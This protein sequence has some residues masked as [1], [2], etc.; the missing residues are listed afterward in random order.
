MVLFF[1]GLFI[2]PFPLTSSLP[3]QQNA[4]FID[5]TA[6]V[7]PVLADG[8]LNR[9]IRV[10]VYDEPNTTLPDYATGG[11][12]TNTISG[13][14]GIL[15][16]AGYQVDTIT[17]TDIQERRLS[18]AN[19][20]VF[21]MVSNIPREKITNHVREFWLGGGGIMGFGVS[22][23]YMSYFGLLGPYY[24][25]DFG[26]EYV[27]SK[28]I[29]ANLVMNNFNVT[30]RHPTATQFHINDEIIHPPDTITVFNNQGLETN[31]DNQVTTVVTEVPNMG[32]VLAIDND[33]KGGRQVI[34]CGNGTDYPAGFDSIIVDSANWIAPR[35][36]GRIVFDLSHRPR[37]GV[38]PWD[39]VSY[40]GY[41]PGFRDL[42]VN[43]TF[44]FDK[45][46][47]SFAGNLTIDRLSSYDILI[48][49]SPDYNYTSSEVAAVQS[50]L[51]Q[52]GS[53]F[54]FGEN[55]NLST[56]GKSNE[57]INSITQN[58]GIYIN[59]TLGT[60]SP[61][62]VDPMLYFT[63]EGCTILYMTSRGFVNVTGDAVGLW[64][65]WPDFNIGSSFL[66]AG[67][68]VVSA[69]MN[70]I[71]DSQLMLDDN[72][73]FAVN[74]AN[75]LSSTKADVVVYQSGTVPTGQNVYR[76][77]LSNALNELG[78]PF[79][80]YTNITYFNLSLVY[81]TWDTVIVDANSISPVSFY[82]EILE[83]MENGGKLIMRDFYFYHSASSSSY[84]LSLDH[85]LGFV[86][87]DSRIISG[88]VP[89]FPWTPEHPVFNV[90]NDYGASNITPDS[91]FLAT[92][93]ANVTLLS[94]ATA[95]A[96]ITESPAINQSAIVLGVGG[97]ALLNM[98]AIAQYNGDTD[99]STYADNYE[100]WMNE[101]AFM[102]KPTVDSPYDM[103]IESGTSNQKITWTP[104]SYNPMRYTIDCNF[105]EAASFNWDGGPISI[106]LDGYAPGTYTFE[107]TVYDGA[108]EIATDTV[109]AIV[110]DTTD[111]AFVDSPDNL[112]YQEGTPE[113][114]M[115]WNFTE[116]LPDSYWLL[117]DN[118]TVES[119]A[120]N[121]A[122]ISVNLGGLA[123][124]VYN[125]TLAVNDTSGNWASSSIVLTVTAMTTTTST[126]TTTTTTPTETGSTSQPPIWG[127]NTIL[128]LMAIAGIAV[129]VIIVVI[130]LRRRR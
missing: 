102:L 35:P 32:I 45:L 40:P 11:V 129:V 78:I 84:D 4:A 86:G 55:P 61:T 21:V 125:V 106:L 94:N 89:V 58:A 119:G 37:L 13:V 26:Q 50:F 10:A 115:N 60:A 99:D 3:D 108:G 31:V 95:I 67:R 101:I 2:T 81:N 6:T 79:M 80:L 96:G 39:D 51:S 56:F 7:G 47:P 72:A 57:Q 111:P 54:A 52:G 9:Q 93:F 69:D 38:D 19:Y 107:L 91:H 36:K 104:S 116:L 33:V 34:I 126:T 70:W 130:V 15:A 16:A 53:L 112:F 100:L 83:H 64:G 92:D 127:D 110:Q 44:T 66:G 75:W 41:Y 25:G 118:L 128:I 5:G 24:E 98:F 76:S 23:G 29:W 48:L 42:L 105:V 71:Q 113:H 1:A 63:L 28:A 109:I 123:E 74:V 18:T 12:L 90:P 20:D 17:H 46:Y 121:G 124:G 114:W 68:V 27:S 85:Y 77:G 30:A 88:P 117:I 103:V 59:D 8:P 49:V 14:L 120:W 43:H 22:I 122:L 87:T 82:D 73:R 65:I 62:Q 97:R